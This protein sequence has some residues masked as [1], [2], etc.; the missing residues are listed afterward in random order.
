MKTIKVKKL[1]SG[2]ISIRDYIVEK[3]I[4]EG[5]VMVRFNDDVMAL[6]PDDLKKPVATSKLFISKW[7]RK[8]YRLCDYEWKPTRQLKIF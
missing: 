3:S 7:G 5:G 1:W 2:C 8:E 6:S 4:G